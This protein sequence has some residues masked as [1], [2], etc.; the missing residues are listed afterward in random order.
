M[1]GFGARE[2]IRFGVPPPSSY[3]WTETLAR[4]QWERLPL[5]RDLEV[6]TPIGD[7]VVVADRPFRL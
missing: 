7:A 6:P 3:L 5:R 2:M 4:T 1:A